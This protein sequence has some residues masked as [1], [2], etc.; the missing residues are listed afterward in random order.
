MHPS[1]LTLWALVSPA[2]GQLLGKKQ[3]HNNGNWWLCD[4][5]LFLKGT[6]QGHCTFG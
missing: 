5:L 3:L 1:A 2:L 4:M 6:G